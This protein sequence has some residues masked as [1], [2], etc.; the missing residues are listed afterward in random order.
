VTRCWGFVGT[1]FNFFIKRRY[2]GWWL[3]YNYITSAALDSGLIISTLIIFFTLYLTLATPPQW[4]GNVGALNTLD[5]QG[6][7]IQSSVAPGAT[8]GPSTWP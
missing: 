8:I 4:F 6:A 7:A 3:Q 1:I 5:F 2:T